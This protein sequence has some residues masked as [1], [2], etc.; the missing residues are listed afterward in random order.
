MDAPVARGRRAV[1]H[2]LRS[3]WT[4]LAAIAC[5]GIA[6]GTLL[7]PLGWNQTSHF[8]LI[9]ALDDGT[10]HID[11]YHKLTGDRARYHGHW[12]S[13]RAPGLAFVTLPMYEALEAVGATH[14]LRDNIGGRNN[15]ET[16]WL[17][18]IWG[19]LLPAVA[20]MLTVRWVGNRVEPGFGTPAAVTLGLGTIVLPFSTVL[21]AHVLSACLGFAAFALLFRARHGPSPGRLRSYALAGACAGYAVTTEYALALVALALAVYGLAQGDVLRRGAAYLGGFVAGLV[22]LGLYNQLA[23][24]SVFHV[25]YADVP[26]QQS[27]FFGINMPRPGVIVQLLL[28]SHGLL[29]L[30]PVVAMGIA[31]TVLLYRRGYRAEAFLIAAIGFGFLLY[32]SGY[33]LPFGG[34]VPGPRFLIATLP[35]VCFPL[36]LA[37]RRW[38]GPTI[39][40]AAA[41]IVALGIPMIT[42]PLPGAETDLRTWTWLLEKGHLTPTAVSIFKIHNEWAALIPTFAAALAALVLAVR[43]APGLIVGWRSLV[44][45]AV[46]AIGW[47][48]FAAAGPNRLGIDRAAAKALVADLPGGHVNGLG[49]DPLTH[50]VLYA[51]VA[52]ALALVSMRVVSAARERRGV[53]AA[54]A[55]TPPRDQLRREP[56]GGTARV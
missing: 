32:S 27:G 40:L 49:R 33:F 5:V 19:A 10:A 8:A 23:F 53:D 29:T 55:A 41:S 36:A 24:G 22:P 50:I 15:S 31:G 3:R 39:A 48:I 45:G 54:T 25:G 35:F 30:S 7:E 9:R 21:F 12:Y 46:L 20:L 37:Y 1:S 18:G 4:A 38:P 17:L 51:L 43:A 28:S 2:R 14:T 16:I 13:P 42:R 11:R 44:A 56:V 52:C 6:A 26:N 34:A 47:A